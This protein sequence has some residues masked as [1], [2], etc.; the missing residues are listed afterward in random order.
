MTTSAAT[1][2]TGVR[3]STV[4]VAGW[5]F[6]VVATVLLFWIGVLAVT[7]PNTAHAQNWAEA[8]IG[9]DLLE[10]IGL[11]TTGWLVLRRD[12]RVAIAASAPA[13]FLVADAWF[14]IVTSQP[15]WDVVQATVLAFFVELPLAA[16][17]VWIA[18]TAQ[19]WCRA[20]S[21]RR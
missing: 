7:L 11:A 18:F 15:N 13:A 19:R 3:P 14:D 1:R 16:I 9:F 2:R 17:C 5:G 20:P 21:T 10:S 8:W 4:H 12:P 6:V